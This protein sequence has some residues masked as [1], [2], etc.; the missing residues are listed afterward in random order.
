MSK[1][2]DEYYIK[3][4]KEHP[5][6]NEITTDNNLYNIKTIV[7]KTGAPDIHTL[8]TNPETYAPVL[9]KEVTNQNTRISY[10][11]TIITFMRSTD[12]KQDHKPIYNVW[13]THMM[14]DR[15]ERNKQLMNHIPTQRQKDTHYDWDVILKKRNSYPIDSLEHLL[16]GIYTYMPPRRQRDYAKLR[17]YT[18]P[19]Y[20]PSYDH[21][22]LHINHR[23]HGPFMFIKEYKNSKLLKPFW[24]KEI[25]KKF[26][27]SVKASLKEKPREY[28]FCKPDGSPYDRVNA[29][30]KFNNGLLKKMFNNQ[31][32]SVN[33][34]RHSHATYVNNK[35]G[36]TVAERV[37]S[38]W[39]MGHSMKKDMI[40]AFAENKVKLPEVPATM[41]A[42]TK[43]DICYRVNK[44]TG[45]L[46]PFKCPKFA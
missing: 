7:K 12:L 34:L 23:D 15:K 2:S 18:D 24:N 37:K 21:N 22:F 6:S 9:K 44:K 13:Y 35:S 17:V 25:P 3:A 38:A 8:L 19:Q 29:F 11:I 26:I 39:Q 14:D 36:V 1:T 32:M 40:Y 41:K 31:K 10:Y 46:E 43:H 20:N 42:N 45:A 27:D 16:L 33:A 4:L 5:L 28:L 30:T